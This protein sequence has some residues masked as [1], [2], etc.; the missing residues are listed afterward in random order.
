MPS[1]GNKPMTARHH[2]G[3][4]QL[5][6]TLQTTQRYIEGDTQKKVNIVDLI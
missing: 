3:N 6:K 1:L 4:P 2:A 5:N